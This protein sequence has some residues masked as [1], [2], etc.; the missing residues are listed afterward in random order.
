MF[1]RISK[2]LLSRSFFLFGARGTGKTTW[3]RSHFNR[4]NSTFV[5]LL[6]PSDAEIFLAHPQKFEAFLEAQIFIGKRDLTPYFRWPSQE[7]PALAFFKHVS[8]LFHQPGRLPS[9]WY[10]GL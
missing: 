8:I 9:G 1:R 3:I 4:G 2:P 6:R 10:K 5:D 7:R